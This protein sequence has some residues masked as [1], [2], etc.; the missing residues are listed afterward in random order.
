MILLRT[1][2]NSK[3][4]KDGHLSISQNQ[5]QHSSKFPALLLRVLAISNI[6]AKYFIILSTSFKVVT[7]I[8]ETFKTPIT[9]VVVCIPMNMRHVFH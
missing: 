1:S 8:K 9:K 7:Q 6:L 5:E 3:G 4:D 2:E